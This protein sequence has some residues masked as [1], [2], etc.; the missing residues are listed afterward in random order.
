MTRKMIDVQYPVLDPTESIANISIVMS[1][2]EADGITIKDAF[3]NKNNSLF[4]LINNKGDKTGLLTVK[5]GDAYP[6]SMLGD[7]IIEIAKG[8]SAIQLQDL[9]RFEKSDESIDLD[10]SEGFEGEIFAIAKW[11]GV[12]ARRF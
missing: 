5:A 8:I 12:S 2:V 11:A 1:K 10:F 7:I 6:N 9:S 3:S 4:I